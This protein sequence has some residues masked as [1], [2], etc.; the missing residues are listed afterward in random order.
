MEVGSVRCEQSILSQRA[1][2]KSGLIGLYFI[3]EM[4]WH[5]RFWWSP[6]WHKQVSSF[7]LPHFF[8]SL[9]FYICSYN[10]LYTIYIQF[11]FQGLAK[12]RALQLIRPLLSPFFFFYP[13]Y[14]ASGWCSGILLWSYA[15]I[16]DDEL[17]GNRFWHWECCFMRNFF[18]C[19]SRIFITWF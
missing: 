13:I 8:H 9:D 16:L 11:C 3:W 19:I 7:A 15:W 5:C 2:S 14:F 18:R 12:P 1:I 4:E 6:Q 17:L 10:L